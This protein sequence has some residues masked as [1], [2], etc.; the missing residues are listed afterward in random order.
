MILG[1]MPGD[2]D[3]VRLT[4]VMPD[5]FCVV[6]LAA[7]LAPTVGEELEIV[8]AMDGSVNDGYCV[9]CAPMA[10]EVFHEYVPSKYEAVSPAAC[11]AR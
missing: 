1:V 4:C 5:M 3:E 6:M 9:A 11:G 7:T 8:M 2:S 10:S